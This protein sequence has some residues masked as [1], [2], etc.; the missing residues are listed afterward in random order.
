MS[1]GTRADHEKVYEHVRQA[2]KDVGKAI[3]ILADLQ[4]PKIRLGTFADGPVVLADG[5]EFT[6]TT[7]AVDGDASRC[8]TTYAGLT[9]DV[10]A[11]DEILIDDGRVRLRATARLRHR[12]HH[13]GRDRRAGQQPQGHQPARACT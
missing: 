8:S 12:R 13:Q 7:D 6:I 10:N 4:G 2:S 11:G 1:H 5:D 9:G 3:A